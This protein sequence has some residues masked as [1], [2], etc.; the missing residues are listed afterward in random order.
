MGP[1]REGGGCKCFDHKGLGLPELQSK[2]V[3]RRIEFQFIRKK[4]SKMSLGAKKV[5]GEKDLGAK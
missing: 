3:W 5:V 2:K 1:K 4:R